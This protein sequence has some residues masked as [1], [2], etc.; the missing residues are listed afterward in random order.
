[1]MSEFMD[2]SA[3]AKIY[4]V[5]ITPSLCRVAEEKARARGWTN[6][7]IVE[8]DACTFK[9]KEKATLVT[10]S[11]SL[12]SKSRAHCAHAL[13]GDARGPCRLAGPAGSISACNCEALS[14]WLG[15]GVVR[16]DPAVHGC[17]GLRRVPPGRGR[18]SWASQTS[19]TFSSSDSPQQAG[20]PA[21]PRNARQRT[22]LDW[23]PSMHATMPGTVHRETI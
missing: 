13:P 10:S 8:G 19:F 18:S 1:M 3:F 20:P 6:V 15:P 9:P 5:D 2:L 23:R 21:L 17:G 4:V 7:E 14:P 16:S 11:N 12:S 22:H